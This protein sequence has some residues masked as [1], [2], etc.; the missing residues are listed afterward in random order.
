MNDENSNIGA[1]IVFSTK[2]PNHAKLF[3]VDTGIGT[4]IFFFAFLY[5]S[6]SKQSKFFQ[7]NMSKQS[8]NRECVL[9]VKIPKELLQPVSSDL[10]LLPAEVI[11]SYMSENDKVIRIH[12]LFNSLFLIEKVVC[13]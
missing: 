5:L 4:S 10:V 2:R 3:E 13:F 7:D 6:C 1:G 8:M 11:S 12:S 9:C